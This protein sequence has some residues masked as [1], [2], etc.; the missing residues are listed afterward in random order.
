MQLERD[1]G[2]RIAYGMVATYA[3]FLYFLGPVTPLIAE[4]LGVSLTLA[5]LTGVALAAG[6]VLSGLV[7]PSLIRRWGRRAVAL[8][9]AG[10]LA[11]AGVLLAIVPSFPGVLLAVL[12]AAACGSMLMNVASAALSDRHG[13]SGPRALTEA[14]ALASLAGLLGPLAIGIGAATVIKAFCDSFSRFIGVN[15]VGSQGRGHT[16]RI[17]PRRQGINSG[18]N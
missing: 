8:S 3:F 1:A 4:Q 13:P 9:A 11:T 15:T 10:G 14:N 17:E 18:F 16:Q 2:T 6:L 7:G 12:V 5:G